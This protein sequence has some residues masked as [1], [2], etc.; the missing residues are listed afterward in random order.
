MAH[1]LRIETDIKRLSNSIEPH[2]GGSR[3]AVG[4][5]AAADQP[6]G[7]TPG[8]AVRTG[9]ARRRSPIRM[10]HVVAPTLAVTSLGLTLACLNQIPRLGWVL[11][12]VELVIL[13]ALGSR[14]ARR[15]ALLH[16][17]A[18]LLTATLVAAT[19]VFAHPAASPAPR[20]Q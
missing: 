7:L 17:S 13:G 11:A 15:H 20:G 8:V 2:R 19:A 14:W 18:W 5:L 16:I 6:D 4:R 10:A 3:V 12:E 9:D 1:E